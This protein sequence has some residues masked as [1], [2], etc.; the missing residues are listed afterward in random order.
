MIERAAAEG[1]D[2]SDEP[3][4]D[5]GAREPAE[6]G[7]NDGGHDD[8]RRAPTVDP[9]AKSQPAEGGRAEVDE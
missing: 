3:G 4:P 6:G 5:P 7:R 8:P 9:A 1:H 2:P